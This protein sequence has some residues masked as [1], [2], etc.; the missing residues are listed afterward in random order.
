LD[1]SFR[2][3]GGQGQLYGLYF[4]PAVA[5]NGTAI[6]LCNGFGKEYEIARSALSATARD[7]AARGFSCL[8][9]DY[10]GYADSDG[11]FTDATVSTMTADI[12]SALDELRRRSGAS[13]LALLGL[14]F[15]ATLAALVAGR[16]PDVSRLVLWEPL[17][18]P[19][20]TLYQALR[21]SVTMQTIIFGKV[22]FSREQI[23]DNVL[24]RRPSLADGYDFN[25]IDDGFP[26]GAEL[27]EQLQAVDL[28]ER[29]PATAAPTLI[30]NVVKTSAPPASDLQRF[31]DALKQRGTP[32]RLETV[33]VP[34]LPWVHEKVIATRFLELTEATGQWLET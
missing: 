2:F 27:V 17:P 8:R 9:F 26:L 21:Q 23:V 33:T 14:R 4:P 18:S 1:T 3:S 32:C 6:V 25:I 12:E 5:P 20:K 16:R 30:L 31:R 34:C 13:H 11:E 7:L 10:A 15:G 28:I 19:W 24:H 29:P 22:H